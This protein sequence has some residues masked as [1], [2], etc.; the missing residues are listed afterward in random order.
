VRLTLAV[1]V[2]IAVTAVAEAYPQFQL[3]KSAACGD[4]HLSPAGGGLLNDYG[5]DE[6]GST[7]SRGG[8]GRFLHNA[9]DPPDWFAI[10]GDFR[11][12]FA[13]K[14]LSATDADRRGEGASAQT[15]RSDLLI[16]PMQADVN[17]RLMKGSF[18]LAFTAGIRGVPRDEDD[19]QPVFVEQLGSRE[20]YIA[21]SFG[22]QQL[23]LGRF[24]PVFGL[25]LH[26]HTA[27]VRRFMGLY[28]Y[29]EPYALE[30]ARYGQKT[31]AHLTAFVPQPL[32]ILGSGARRSGATA[33]IERRLRDD[34]VLGGQARAAVGSDDAVFTVGGVAKRWMPD[35]DLL[36]L[37]EL[38]LQRQTFRGNG[39]ARTQI[40]SYGSVATWA[41][42]GVLVSSALHVWEPDLT[43][44]ATT[45]Y[46]YELGVQYFPRAHFEAHLLLRASA[47]GGTV[48]DP[49]YLSMLQLHYY[50]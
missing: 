37:A 17:L 50:P 47:Q 28:T 39:P 24:L 12:A 6:A 16:F 18:A 21:Y 33:L 3:S 22:E 34:L 13:G 14:R 30:Y 46:A 19:E 31:D 7:I 44:R 25:R 45:R 5:R 8:D 32:E 38:D 11:F 10:G 23:R 4:C 48:E 2:L 41:A 1:L 27:Y 35:A 15:H 40:A 36:F 43:L 20:H 9:W 49:G 42:R 26:D 29:E